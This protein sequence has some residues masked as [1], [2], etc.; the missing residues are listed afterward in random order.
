MNT[1]SDLLF[2]TDK[3]RWEALLGRNPQAD[4]SFFYAVKT[5]GVYCRP[6][7][8]ARRPNRQNVEFFST[9]AEAEYAGYRACQR[10]HPHQA[11]YASPTPAAITCACRIIEQSESPPVLRELAANVGLSP[12]HFHRLFK[13]TL[14]LTPKAYAA[15]CRTRR[16]QGELRKTQTVTEALYSA[17]YGSS[18]RCYEH[19]IDHLGMTPADYQKGGVGQHIRHAL[20]ECALGWLL[21]AA[22]ERGICAVE[23][24]DQPDSL[25][26]Q[27]RLR[28]SAAEIHGTDL[29]L[30]TW[31]KQVLKY[32][33]EPSCGFDVPL[34]IRG[35]AFQRRVWQALQ[36]I[37]PGSTRTYSEIAQSLGQPKA[38]RAVARACAANALAVLIPCHRVVRG[39]GGLGGYRWNLQRKQALLEREAKQ[40]N[41]VTALQTGADS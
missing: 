31:V 18:S 26:E 21:V 9:C 13:E 7:C 41:P 10:C 17:G 36:A 30:S 8:S 19:A 29:E 20:V 39:D 5:T 37:P 35:T 34:D 16:F 28:F 23:F 38:A 11:S 24:S 22:T 2:I 40:R 27:L 4:G 6:S 32:L 3:Q 12:S 15:A 25:E 14:G 1:S 33:E